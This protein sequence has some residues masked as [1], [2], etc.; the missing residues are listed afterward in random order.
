[1]INSITF[2]RCFYCKSFIFILFCIDLKGIWEGFMINYITFIRY[3]ARK[4]WYFVLIWK[5]LESILYCFIWNLREILFKMVIFPLI[6]IVIWIGMI[7][8]C[9]INLIF[10]DGGYLLPDS[11]KSTFLREIGLNLMILCVFH[12]YK[13]DKKYLFTRKWL[14]FDEFYAFFGDNFYRKN[15]KKYLFTRNRLK[16]DVFYV[17]FWSEFW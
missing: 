11:H 12:I 6:C 14:D 17:F 13:N 15:D 3:D 2:L 16:F 8:N 1:M 9:I 7:I 4:V 5:H 10:M